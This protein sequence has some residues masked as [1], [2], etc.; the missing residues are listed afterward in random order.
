MVLQ[1]MKFSSYVIE[2]RNRFVQ[3]DVALRVANSKMF[4][5]ILLSS[6]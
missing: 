2:L 1:V 3:N 6:Y 4:I 5:E